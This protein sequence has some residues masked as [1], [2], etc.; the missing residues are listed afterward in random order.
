[1]VSPLKTHRKVSANLTALELRLKRRLFAFYKK[2]IMGKISPIER[3]RAEHET[4]VRNI[5]RKAVQDSYL[6]GTE[7]VGDQVKDKEPDFE[8]F[9]SGTDINNIIRLTEVA[10]ASFWLVASRLLLRENEFKQVNNER[11]IHKPNINAEA[12]TLGLA[13]DV[14][15]KGY[16]TAVTSKLP[17]VAS[18]SVERSIISLPSPD[19]SLLQADLPALLDLPIDFEIIR[20]GPPGRLMFLTKEDAKVDPEICKPLNRKVYEP[21]E[22]VPEDET[23]PLHKFCRCMLVP[24]VE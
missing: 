8:L 9:I 11:P 7:T 24:F 2:N 3:L 21:G 4:T 5:I 6:T 13:I 12:A 15:F 1:M 14:V 17:I 23:P 22:V 20:E 18:G 16:N 10:L 19:T